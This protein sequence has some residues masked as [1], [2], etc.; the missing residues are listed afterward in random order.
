MPPQTL[1]LTH[2]YGPAWKIATVPYGSEGQRPY[3]DQ[4]CPSFLE[5]GT[6]TSCVS[7]SGSRMCGGF[8]GGVPGYVY[9]IWGLYA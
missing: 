3:D 1:V 8:L 7:S 4:E 5:K 2:D 6:V 9:C